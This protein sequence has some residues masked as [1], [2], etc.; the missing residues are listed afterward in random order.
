MRSIFTGF[1][2]AVFI[3]ES[4]MDKVANMI[5][6]TVDEFKQTNF[7]NKGDKSYLVSTKFITLIVH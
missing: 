7:Y 3:I 4:I 2:P 1:L 5:G 6:L